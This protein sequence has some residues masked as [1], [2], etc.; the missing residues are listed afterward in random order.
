MMKNVRATQQRRKGVKFTACWFGFSYIPFLLLLFCSV[1]S[2][3]WEADGRRKSGG[4]CKMK[5]LIYFLLSLHLNYTRFL[6]SGKVTR[7]HCEDFI[8]EKKTAERKNVEITR[9]WIRRKHWE[10]GNLFHITHTKHQTVFVHMKIH[11][12]SQ[13]RKRDM[14]RWMEYMENETTKAHNSH[15]YWAKRIWFHNVVDSMRHDEASVNM[16]RH[17]YSPALTN[18]LY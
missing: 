15:R 14:P 9:R 4:M 8:W 16:T 12:I 2:A 6:N 10:S 7:Q 13:L 5:N 3:E 17:S 11:K 1:Y 18:R